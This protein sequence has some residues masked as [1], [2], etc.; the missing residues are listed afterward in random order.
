MCTGL[1]LHDWTIGVSLVLR[2]KMACGLFA[3]PL[4][5]SEGMLSLQRIRKPRFSSTRHEEGY[6]HSA[7]LVMPWPKMVI[8]AGVCIVTKGRQWNAYVMCHVLAE[9]RA[10]TSDDFLPDWDTECPTSAGFSAF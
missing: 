2:E 7:P 8:A 4:E 10:G 5:Q 3:V 9:A 6:F 1:R